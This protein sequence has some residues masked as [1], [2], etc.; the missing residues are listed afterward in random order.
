MKTTTITIIDG[1]I[2]ALLS[3]DAGLIPVVCLVVSGGIN[4]LRTVHRAIEK[5]RPIPVVIVEVYLPFR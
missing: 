2:S 5:D 3:V 4:T 1:K